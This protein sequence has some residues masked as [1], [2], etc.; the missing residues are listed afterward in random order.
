[1]ARP[2]WKGSISFGFVSIPVILQ[3]A[4][5]D[6]GIHFHLLTRDGT[7]RLRQKLFCPDTGKE[8]DFSET[9]RGLEIGKNEYVLVDSSEIQKI[10]PVSG[11]SLEIQQFIRLD[12]LDPLYFDRAYFVTPEESGLKP[13]RLLCEAMEESKTIAIA[14][15]VMREKEYLS[16]MRVAGPGLILHTLHYADEVLSLDDALP[17]ALKSVKAPSK[18]VQV[19]GQLVKAMSKPFDISDFKDDYRERMEALVK[20][21]T[22]GKKFTHADEDHGDETV[23][24][25]INLMEALK[26]SLAAGGS[27]GH[28]RKSA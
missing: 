20:R 16:A 14:R 21:K 13:Y 3:T 24:P 18:E 22:Q 25:T 12:E 2:I 19:A 23:P 27:N 11:K 10:K 5:R 1:M 4:T 9:S 15:F 28:R 26:R 7:C 17:P 8:Y 6:R